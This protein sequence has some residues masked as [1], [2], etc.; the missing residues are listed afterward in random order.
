MD[1]LIVGDQMKF[2]SAEVNLEI[3]Q[4]KVEGAWSRRKYGM[5]RTYMENHYYKAY[6]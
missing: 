5:K 6:K 3:K 2:S 4:T 1:D